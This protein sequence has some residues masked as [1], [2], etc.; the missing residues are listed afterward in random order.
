MIRKLFHIPRHSVRYMATVTEDDVLLEV[1]NNIGIITLN[2]PKALNALD[3]SMVKKVYSIL[4]DWEKSISFVIVRGSGDKSFCAGGDVVAVTKE[5]SKDPKVG[6]SFFRHEYKMNY[7]IGMYKRPYISILDGIT[8]GGGVGISV[9]GT[10]R[11]ATEKTLFAMP[12]TAIGLFPDVGG[13]YVL[14]RLKGKLGLYLAL[15][16]NRLKGTDVVKAGIATHY[17]ESSYVPELLSKLCNTNYDKLDIF[18]NQNTVKLDDKEFSLTPY[19]DQINEYFSAENV[20]DILKYLKNDGSAWALQ[21]AD[22]LSKMSP[23]SLKITKTAL[24]RGTVQNLRQCL[25]MEYRLAV[26]CV[27]A[28][29]SRDFYEGKQKFSIS[30]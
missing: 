30:Y 26:A 9:H 29:V 15:T 11:I 28:R 16:G 4:K 18:L 7:L 3:N 13:T 2:R 12:E 21:T 10:Y 25:I 24:E 23:I 27:D 8:M 1:K 22:T 17:I 5:G 14:P 19:L 6:S 20:E